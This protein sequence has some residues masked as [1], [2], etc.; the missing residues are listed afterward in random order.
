MVPVPTSTLSPEARRVLV[1]YAHTNRR[2]KAQTLAFVANA[3]GS[4]DSY[5]D[6]DIDAD[7]SGSG[8]DPYTDRNADSIHAYPNRDHGTA[9]AHSDGNSATTD[10]DADADTDAD[11]V[12]TRLRQ[13]AL[14]V[15]VVDRPGLSVTRYK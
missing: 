13:S 9:N 5:R 1:G 12:A 14:V 10:I 2:L 7:H 15:L 11:A 3:W 8:S 6:P 4:L